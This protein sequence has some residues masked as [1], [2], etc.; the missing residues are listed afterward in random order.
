M[1]SWESFLIYQCSK[2]LFCLHVILSARERRVWCRDHGYQA[3]GCCY[4]RLIFRSVF[5]SELSVRFVIGVSIFAA[6]ILVVVLRSLS[7][8][9]TAVQFIVVVAVWLRVVVGSLTLS[10]T[11]VSVRAIFVVIIILTCYLTVLLLSLHLHA[12]LGSEVLFDLSYSSD[13]FLRLKESSRVDLARVSVDPLRV[14]LLTVVLIN[15][16]LSIFDI[17]H[18]VE[19]LVDSSFLDVSGKSTIQDLYFLA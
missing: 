8:G 14:L 11:S 16:R 15:S 10:L 3:A 2:F 12:V 18:F 6:H 4:I 5:H 19:N 13:V 17:N 9:A 1:C 7:V